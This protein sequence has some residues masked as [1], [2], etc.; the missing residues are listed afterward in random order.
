KRQKGDNMKKIFVVLLISLIL[1]T[2]FLAGCAKK[3][4][5]EEVIKIG[6]ILPLSGSVAQLGMEELEGINLAINEF[7][8]KVGNKKIVL[9]VED[10]QNNPTQGIN[11]LN[12]LI[13]YDNIKYVIGSMSSV[14]L[15]VKPILE[16]KNIPTIWIGLHPDLIKETRVVFR[17][18]ATAQQNANAIVNK[19]KEEKASKIALFYINDDF[20]ASLKDLITKEINPVI[21]ESFKKDGSDFRTEITKVLSNK[22]DCVVIVGYGT[23]TGFLIKQL[24][25]MGYEGI[26]VG[27]SE[28]GG[29]SIREIAGEY[30][31]NTYYP[32]YYYSPEFEKMVGKTPVPDI[33]VGYVGT[34]L[35][36]NAIKETDGSS[37]AVENYLNNIRDF[38]TKNGK[39]SVIN[40]EI[41]YELIMRKIE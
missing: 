13:E 20:G 7:G 34:Y 39:V 33:I 15:A 31:K 4:K 26:I 28:I 17:N 29:T 16:E 36:L 14:G 22:P 25:V 32:D 18:I 35:L 21:I 19:I 8:G 5:E 2:S 3:E 6:A 38:P 24:R 27:S 12:K 10:S 1:L 40:N 23:A 9:I 37:K 11:S 41:Q 30:L